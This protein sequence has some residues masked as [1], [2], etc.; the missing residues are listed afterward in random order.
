M[1]I[2]EVV[3]PDMN[4]CPTCH[5][6][7]SLDVITT[8]GYYSGV[9]FSHVECPECGMRGASIDSE[10]IEIPEDEDYEQDVLVKLTVRN[11]ILIWNKIGEPDAD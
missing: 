8:E 5:C 3:I 6:D 11:A 10:S 2:N 7:D 9:A 4:N 1:E